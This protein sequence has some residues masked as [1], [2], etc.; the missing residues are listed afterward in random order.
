MPM[1]MPMPLPSRDDLAAAGLG[2]VLL[3]GAAGAAALVAHWVAGAPGAAWYRAVVLK[4]M[5]PQLVLTA[6]LHPWLRRYRL[7][8]AGP[9]HARE[10]AHPGPGTL[11]VETFVIASLAYCAVAPTLLSSDWPGWPALRMDGPAEQLGTYL[12]MTT[13]VTAAI[14]L[15]AAW[16]AR[17][18]AQT[19][20]GHGPAGGAGG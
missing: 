4:G 2:V 16:L 7:R 5:V 3:V 13:T 15:P 6:L 9:A 1:P 18:R 8:R 12:G 19:Q 20:T 10:A 14:R 11:V 17:R